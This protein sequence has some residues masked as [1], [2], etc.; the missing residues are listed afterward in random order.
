MELIDL[1]IIPLVFEK[2]DQ[3]EAQLKDA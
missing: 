2:M 3:E 1:V